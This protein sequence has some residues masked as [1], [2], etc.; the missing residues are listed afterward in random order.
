MS[1][2]RQNITSHELIGL[3]VTIVE[4]TNRDIVGTRGKV[5]DESRNTLTMESHGREKIAAKHSNTFRFTLPDGTHVKVLGDLL[6]ARPEDRA[7][8]RPRW[9]NR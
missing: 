4:G 1:I 9:Y 6:I 8:K 5:V 7:A 2:D 3:D